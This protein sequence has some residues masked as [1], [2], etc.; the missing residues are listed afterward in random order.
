VRV[1]REQV[2]VATLLTPTGIVCADV[3][4]KLKVLELPGVNVPELLL[5]VN[6]PARLNVPAPPDMS[7]CVCNALLPAMLLNVRFPPTVTVPVVTV[8]METRLDWSPV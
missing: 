5:I 3:P 2:V 1:V 6:A 7:I 4:L 8:N